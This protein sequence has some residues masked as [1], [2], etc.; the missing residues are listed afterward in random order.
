MVCEVYSFFYSLTS[1]DSALQTAEKISE[2]LQEN[3][4]QIDKI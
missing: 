3:Q 2:L 1:H 4:I